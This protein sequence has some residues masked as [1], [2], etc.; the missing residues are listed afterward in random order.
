MLATPWGQQRLGGVLSVSKA[1]TV[2]TVLQP[3]PAAMSA[4]VMPAK[5]TAPNAA[6][7]AL[8]PS[9]STAS[10]SPAT[11][12]ITPAAAESIAGPPAAASPAL[13]APVSGVPSQPTPP[14]AAAA[15]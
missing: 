7:V 6:P 3:G 5:P 2:F 15:R 8:A 13:V 12:V 9:P 1:D 4:Q 11:V 14:A 10:A